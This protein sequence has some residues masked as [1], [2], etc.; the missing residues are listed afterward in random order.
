ME[1]RSINKENVT[2]IIKSL[3]KGPQV[4]LLRHAWSEHNFVS[5]TL[6]SQNGKFYI[7]W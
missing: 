6:I 2:K 7:L 1:S 5:E 4:L 3:Q